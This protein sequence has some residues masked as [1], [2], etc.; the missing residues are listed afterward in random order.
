MERVSS[1]IEGLDVVLG[2][3]FFRGASYLVVG[4]VG[5]GK[6]IFSLQWLLDGLKR[7][8][9]VLYITLAESAK[10]IRHN[11]SGL[12][13]DLEG[14]EIKD[15]SPAATEPNHLDDY[16]IFFP[17][18]V[19][20][21]PFW[22]KVYRALEEVCPARLV[23]DSVSV[24]HDLSANE[25]SFRRRLIAFVKHLF[26]RGCTTLFLADAREMKSLV[27][28]SMAVDG[29][30]RLHRRLSK[31]HFVTLRLLE[32]LKFRGSDFVSGHHPFRITSEGLKLFP[33]LVER[34]ASRLADQT[35]FSSGIEELDE[36]LGGGIEA[37]TV[38]LI[39][40]PSGLGKSS[41]ALQ[42]LTQIVSSQQ[43]KGIYFSFEESLESALRRCAR[44]GIPLAPLLEEGRLRFVRVNPLELYPD[45]FLA[46]VRKEVEEGARV[47]VLDSTKVYLLAMEDYGNIRA[48]FYNLVAFLTSHGV[49]TFV[50]NEI[51]DFLG[52][53]KISEIGISNLADNIVVLRYLEHEGRIMKVI[54][55]L[56]KRL[57]RCQPD[58]RSFELTAEGPKV[59]EKLKHLKG[60]LSGVPRIG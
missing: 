46:V 31:T 13:W 3:G 47:V 41:L 33:H 7:G 5:T 2:G 16:E 23:L 37:G 48:H 45:E 12:S 18:E 15:F 20:E 10:Q 42:F 58:L 22:Q 36:L 39:T 59:G 29:V 34:P 54:N 57:G 51:E 30:L 60:V 19:E 4:D 8:E 17:S 26:D 6:T 38:T 53:S 52:G 55:C 40:G 50:V 27:S 25:Y 1:G 32:V 21:E 49:T 9:K 43:T 44:L 56:K 28:I 35:V 14:L 24:F 11:V